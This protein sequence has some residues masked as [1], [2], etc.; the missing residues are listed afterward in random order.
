MPPLSRSR[1][2]KT[3]AAVGPSCVVIL[4]W[5]TTPVHRAAAPVSTRRP[6]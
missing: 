2:L 3:P 5:K 6:S 1:T 4:L